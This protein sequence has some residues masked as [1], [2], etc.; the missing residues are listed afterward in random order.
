MNVLRLIQRSQ[1]LFS[2][3]AMYVAYTTTGF[4]AA[5]SR[6]NATGKDTGSFL[7][8]TLDQ[9][10]PRSNHPVDD[11]PLFTYQV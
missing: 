10:M 1:G 6:L 9:L 8:A 4:T 5:F 7:S 11:Q 3:V 2:L